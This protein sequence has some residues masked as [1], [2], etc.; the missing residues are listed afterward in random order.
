MAWFSYTEGEKMKVKCIYC[1]YEWDY[2]GEMYW[3]TCPRCLRK[4]RIKKEKYDG[5]KDD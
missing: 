3:A 2:N 1:G 4:F 5:D